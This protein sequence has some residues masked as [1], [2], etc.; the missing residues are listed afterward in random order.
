MVLDGAPV[1]PGS[2]HYVQF[3]YTLPVENAQS[4][5]QSLDYPVSGRVAFFV[6]NSHLDFTAEGFELTRTQP[7]NNQTY[8]IYE[9]LTPPAPGEV[10]IYSLTLDSTRT[11]AAPPP[12]SSGALALLLVVVGVGL[13]GSA[14]VI[15]WRGRQ[16]SA[17]ES[18]DA[19]PDG[20]TSADL[21]EQIAQLDHVFK[22][23]EIEKSEYQ[24]KREQLKA[25]LMQLMQS[26]QPDS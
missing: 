10:Y 1:L 25:R 2:E 22:A 4:V 26:E 13:V 20:E 18:A 5:S 8:D 21:I 15:V 7:F 14:A 16:N 3:G 24:K 9:R 11:G 23:G 12:V 19:S 17:D 6:E